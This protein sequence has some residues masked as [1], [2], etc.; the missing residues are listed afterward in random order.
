MPY[1]VSGRIPDIKKLDY[2]AGYSVHSG[3]WW[4]QGLLCNLYRDLQQL[5]KY[6]TLRLIGNHLFQRQATNFKEGQLFIFCRD[7]H[8]CVKEQVC[9]E[10]GK[11]FSTRSSLAAH[12]RTHT[13]ERPFQVRA[14][15]GIL[16]FS[17]WPKNFRLFQAVRLFF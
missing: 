6:K 17:C 16:A 4:Q 9:E 1:P 2:L 8:A 5:T 12:V 3:T 13:G 11:A 10:C 7:F 14:S 15:S